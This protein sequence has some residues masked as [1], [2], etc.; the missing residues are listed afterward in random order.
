MLNGFGIKN[1]LNELLVTWNICTFA[2]TKTKNNHT[3]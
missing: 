1:L 3:V 2:V